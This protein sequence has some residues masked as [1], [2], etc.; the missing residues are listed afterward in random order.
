[1]WRCE[2][3]MICVRGGVWPLMVERSLS[4]MTGPGRS[5]K[6]SYSRK[7]TMNG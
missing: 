3:R 2:E 6:A 1:M 5:G 4:P 7:R